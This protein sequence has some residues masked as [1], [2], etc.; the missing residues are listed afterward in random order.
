MLAVSLLAFAGG[1]TLGLW[2]TFPALP[3]A[4]EP[5]VAPGMTVQHMR[6]TWG[7][8][9]H[10]WYATPRQGQQNSPAKHTRTEY[11]SYAPTSKRAAVLCIVEN[12]IVHQV[13]LAGQSQD[14]LLPF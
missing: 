9:T 14:K 7:S 13:V 12:G 8:P 2:W 3:Q 6:R 4:H 11:W 5:W 10:I 1:I